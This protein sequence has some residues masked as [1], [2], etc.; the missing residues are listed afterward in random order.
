[1]VEC[2][3]KLAELFGE[4]RFKMSNLAAKLA[5]HLS[6]APP[7]TFEYTV[8]AFLLPPSSFLAQLLR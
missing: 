5:P 3:D 7:L 8:R 1:M 6:T 4:R 2:D